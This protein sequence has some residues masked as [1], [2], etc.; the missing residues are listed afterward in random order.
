M[1]LAKN[2]LALTLTIFECPKI[3]I[4]GNGSEEQGERKNE[5]VI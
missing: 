2:F 4:C 5:F 1:V 3:F